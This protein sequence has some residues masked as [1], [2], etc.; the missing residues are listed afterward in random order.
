M[1]HLRLDTTLVQFLSDRLLATGEAVEPLG[2]HYDE[3]E[4]LRVVSRKN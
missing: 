4:N 2:W 1:Q 3:A